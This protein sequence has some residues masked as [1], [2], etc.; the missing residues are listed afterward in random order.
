M[1]TLPELIKRFGDHYRTE[2]ISYGTKYEFE[3]E[4]ISVDVVTADSVSISETYFSDYPLTA[5]GEPPSDIVNTILNTNAPGERWEKISGHALAADNPG[6]FAI[7]APYGNSYML[8]FTDNRF[9]AS[10]KYNRPQPEGV[11]WL[12]TVARIPDQNSNRSAN[13]PPKPTAKPE[14]G[15]PQSAEPPTPSGSGTGFF[16]SDDG[17]LVNEPTRGCKCGGSAFAG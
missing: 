3:S 1:E 10:V 5:K 8:Q 6:L 17:F 2:V 12:M 13:A 15:S 11:I 14:S 4:K 7:A 16:V 9:I